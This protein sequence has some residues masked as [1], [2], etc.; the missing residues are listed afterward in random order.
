MLVLYGIL[1]VGLIILDQLSKYWA[2]TTLLQEGFIEVIPGAFEFRYTE[3]RG[4]AFSMLQD[5]RWVFIPV[6]I[7]M[8]LVLIIMLM[9][10]PMRQSK[11][12]CISTILVIAG[13]IG[14]LIDRIV[15][16]YV[17]DY[18]YFSLID[19][20][21]FNF[22]DCCVVVGAILLSAYMIFGAKNLENL[23]LRTLF[24]GINKK[25]EESTHC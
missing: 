13:A 8:T 14:N 23:P 11:L 5:Q 7:L 6:S 9:R 22:A 12:F 21:I 24:L 15:L 17:I 2:S 16:G 4:V 19:F 25:Q 18:L 1:A 10:S 3:N 20:P